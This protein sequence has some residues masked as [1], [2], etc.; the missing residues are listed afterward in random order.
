MNSSSQLTTHNPSTE[1][2]KLAPAER[3]EID[4]STRGPLFLFF[5]SSIFWLVAASFLG[6]LASLKLDFPCLLDSCAMLTYGRIL[7]ASV[8]ALAYGWATPAA[9]GVGLWLTARLSRLPLLHTKLLIS[10]GIVWNLGVL[11]GTC[12]ILIGDGLSH[13]LLAFPAYS[14]P[15]LFVSYAFI[16]VWAIFTFHHRKPGALYVSEWFLLAAF[17]SFPWLFASA[18]VVLAWKPIQASAQGAVEAWY[19]SGFNTLWLAPVALA[20]AFYFIPKA[21]GRPIFSYYLS[22]LA[23]WT[24]VLFSGWTGMSR[25]IGG[26]F[27]AW[28]VS[29]GIVASFLILIPV[30]SVVLNLH[31]TLNHDYAVAGWCPTMRFTV[32]GVFSYLATYVFAAIVAIPGVSAVTNF[33]DV[34][35]GISLL[36]TYGFFGMIIFGA[37]YYILPRING[38][39]W[40]CVKLI[41]WHFYLL[42]T[43]LGLSVTAL[44]LGGFIQGF[45]LFNVTGTFRSSVEFVAPFRLLNSIGAILI[46]GANLAF[47]A[48]FVLM[49]LKSGQPKSGP[50]LLA[51]P[52]TTSHEPAAV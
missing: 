37:I 11:L 38:W 5:G 1:T 7:P 45:A 35:A 44:I 29:A 36:G 43:G 49:L 39:E 52:I 47:A 25:Y 33:T 28:M 51:E 22:L 10:A 19:S 12:G 21:I 40:P 13:Q 26:P 16:A 6:L 42:I 2:D 46:F 41:N 30:F 27:P 32:V 20:A 50:A 34:S 4:A 3:A 17:L 14:T 24:L 31:L 23:F 48:Q 8:N 9:I 15:I 18:N